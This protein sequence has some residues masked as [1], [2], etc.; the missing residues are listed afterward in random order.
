MKMPNRR[1][2]RSFTKVAAGI[3][4]L[5]LSL[6]V[7]AQAR[8]FN[9]PS[10]DLK[11]AL[12]AYIAE[13]KLQIVYNAADLKGK[14][15][16]GVSG[17]MEAEKALDV[18]LEGTDLKL[19]RDSSGAVIIFFRSAEQASG[20]QVA[21]LE[22]VEVF[23]NLSHLSDLTR[24]GTRMDADPMT[25]PLTITSVDKDLLK[26]QQSR[27]LSEALSNVGGVADITGSGG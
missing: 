5:L 17:A 2:S 18:L 11:S 13:T 19:R 10:G 24:T 3:S 20:S 22:R 16:K 21:T 8:D 4:A 12:D 9:I 25:I 23:A 1:S 6:A 15:T 26:Q 7:H 27:S 14:T